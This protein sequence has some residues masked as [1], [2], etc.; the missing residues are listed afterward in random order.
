MR[1]RACTLAAVGA[2]WCGLVAAPNFAAAPRLESSRSILAAVAHDPHAALAL[3]AW[4][5]DCV[6]LGALAEELQETR[7]GCGAASLATLLRTR[8]CDTP[9]HLVGCMCR[10][11]GGGTTLGRLARVAGAL[12]VPAE[13]DLV[14]D[15]GA[16]ALPAILHLHRG[17]FVVLREWRGPVATLVDPACGR[18][19]IRA[20]A[21]RRAASGAVLV[22]PRP[23]SPA[24]RPA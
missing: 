10:V 23:R 1:R 19:R 18:I 15:L 22:V 14:D 2:V 11:P 17:H 3:W 7:D 9:Q 6:W 12:G 16:V 5:P 4:G 20:A 21:L 24:R 8:G 13:V